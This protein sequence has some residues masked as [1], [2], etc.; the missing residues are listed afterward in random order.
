[1]GRAVILTVLALLVPGG[2]V[3]SARPVTVALDYVRAHEGRFRLDADDIDGLRLTRSYRS[4]SGAVHLQ[5][6][7]V[8]R[9]I[10]VFGTGLV[11]NVDAE[12]RLINAG[13]APLPDPHVDSIEPRLPAPAGEDPSLTIVGDRLAWRVLR[14]EDD[15]HVYD[16]IVDATSGETLYRANRVRAASGLVFENYPGAPIRGGQVTKTFSE[17]GDDPWLTLSDRLAGDNAHVYSDD[18]D[19]IHGDPGDPSP[20]V[21]DEIP[22]SA[23]GVWNYPQDA[24]VASSPQLCPAAGCT[25]DRFHAGAFS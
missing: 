1:M 3:A 17:T 20:L 15:A 12:G 2:A 14:H 6:E 7:Q 13:G 24:R 5:W 9:G 4:G 10:P 11:A 16:T 22:P 23:A 21:A 18:D 19:D 8:Y 25:W